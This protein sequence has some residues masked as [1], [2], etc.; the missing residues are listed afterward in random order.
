MMSGKSY[1]RFTINIKS[2]LTSPKGEVAISCESFDLSV[3]FSLHVGRQ[4]SS[5]QGDASDCKLH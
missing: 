3:G 5:P 4:F 1:P 2:H